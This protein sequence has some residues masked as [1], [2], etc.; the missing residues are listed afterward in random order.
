MSVHRIYIYLNGGKP[1]SNYKGRTLY[2]PNDIKQ[3]HSSSIQQTHC[4]ISLHMYHIA[5]HI[6]NHMAN[7]RSGSGTYNGLVFLY[8]EYEK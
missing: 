5:S 4:S 1:I 3:R 7:K 8:N 6:V 2:S